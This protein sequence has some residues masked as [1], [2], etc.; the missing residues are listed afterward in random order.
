MSMRAIKDYI[1]NW[2]DEL[3]RSQNRLGFFSFYTPDM[4]NM[5]M[6]T[7]LRLD[8]ITIMLLEAERNSRCECKEERIRRQMGRE[9]SNTVSEITSEK[10]NQSNVAITGESD[11][12]KKE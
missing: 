7:Q 8:Y 6:D 11:M 1:N 3:I 4:F 5:N 2:K 9:I 10:S 12:A